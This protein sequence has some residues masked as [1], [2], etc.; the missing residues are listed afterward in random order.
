M[1]TSAGRFEQLNIEVEL[2][3]TAEQTAREVAA[4]S[5]L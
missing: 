4:M 2:G 1:S 5:E 3:F